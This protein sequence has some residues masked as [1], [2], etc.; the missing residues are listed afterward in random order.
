VCASQPPEG[1][2]K[3]WKKRIGIYNLVCRKEYSNAARSTNPVLAP[4]GGWVSLNI[5]SYDSLCRALASGGGDIVKL[6][7][8]MP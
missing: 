1:G 6:V 2:P 7:L 3:N 4:A 8:R 5:D